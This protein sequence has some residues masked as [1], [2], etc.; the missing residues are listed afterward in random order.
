[1]SARATAAMPMGMGVVMIGSKSP[2]RR[3]FPITSVTA[4]TVQ[5][6]PPS[7]APEAKISRAKTTRIDAAGQTRV[8]R[9]T[10]RYQ[11]PRARAVARSGRV[12]GTR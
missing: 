1:M 4:S 12:R 11:A 6:R 3:R 9:Q 10:F 8:G 2:S 7:G 5:L